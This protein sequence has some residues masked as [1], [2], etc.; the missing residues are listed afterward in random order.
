MCPAGLHLGESALQLVRNSEF[1]LP[2]LR[3]QINKYQRQLV[4]HEKKEEDY[5]KSAAASSRAYQAVSSFGLR[6]TSCSSRGLLSRSKLQCY[7]GVQQSRH[8]PSC[9]RFCPRAAA[10]TRQAG[11]CLPQCSTANSE[12]SCQ[13]C[14]AVVPK[15]HLLCRRAGWMQPIR[16]LWTSSTA[17]S[18][19]NRHS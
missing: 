6:Q 4:D 15:C 3:A 19:S 1:E 11:S 13:G 2:F 10:A 18:S 8:R 16:C 7:T 17:P 9:T 5:Q 12:P 14:I